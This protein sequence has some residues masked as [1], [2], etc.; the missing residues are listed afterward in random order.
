M[1]QLSTSA[2]AVPRIQPVRAARAGRVAILAAGA[3]LFLWTQLGQAALAAVPAE[4]FAD[5]AETV[6]P[7]V[8]YV[9]S[10]HLEMAQ[11][12]SALAPGSL[13]DLMRRYEQQQMPQSP[14]PVEALGSGFIISA[15]GYVVTNNHVV[16]AADSV[17]VTLPDGQKFQA[18]LV[19]TDPQTDLA[20]LKIQSDQPLPH[21]SFGDSDTLRVGDY[22]MA[23]GNPFG[24]GGTVTAGIVSAR[25]RDIHAGPYD[26]FIQTDAAINRGNSGGPMFNLAGEVVGINTAIYSP[27]GGSVGIGFAIPSNLA[28]QVVSDLQEHGSVERGWLGVRIQ[29]VTEDMQEALGLPAAKGALVAEVF[30]DGPAAEAKLRQGDVILDFGGKP[31]ATLKDLTRAVAATPAGSTAEVKVWR[32]GHE[33]VFEVR[34]ARQEAQQ[35]DAGPVSPGAGP[36]A[37]TNRQLGALLAPLDDSLREKLAL[38]DNAEGV[39][40]VGLEPEGPAAR[41]GLAV[42]DVIEKVDVLSIE[43]PRE[44]QQALKAANKNVVLLLVNRAGQEQYVTVRLGDA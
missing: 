9:A 8:V 18:D 7:A 21:V 44:L 27:S 42:G 6:T 3:S 14:Q 43:S 40:I 35:G 33:Q 39:A 25:G 29:P 5:L 38:A 10:T 26:D 32:G 22:V 36:K 11:E 13:E 24:L 20:L 30:A 4:G 31:V 2:I 28:K 34:V 19:G 12:G 37:E 1:H 41:Q 23:V 16:D 15:D 17:T